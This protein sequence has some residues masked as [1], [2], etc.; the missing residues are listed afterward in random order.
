[1][2]PRCCNNTFSVVKKHSNGCKLII[3]YK[4][5]TDHA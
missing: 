2:R 3:L 5:Y 4:M 1:M